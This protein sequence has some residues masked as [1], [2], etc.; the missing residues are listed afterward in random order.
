MEGISDYAVGLNA[1]K[2]ISSFSTCKQPKRRIEM[3]AQS[4]A[5]ST[6]ANVLKKPYF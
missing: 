4:C 1:C 5:F 3:A 2:V 6:D